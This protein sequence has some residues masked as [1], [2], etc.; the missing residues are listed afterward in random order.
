MKFLDE[1]QS[2]AV[3]RRKIEGTNDDG[4]LANL[5]LQA[6]EGDAVSK[7]EEIMRFI[8]CNLTASKLR[9]D[10]PK[11]DLRRV[12]ERLHFIVNVKKDLTGQAM[13]SVVQEYAD[14]S[15]SAYDALVVCVL[16]HGMERT[17][18]GVDGEEVL[19]KKLY[20]PFTA[21]RTL[22]SKPKL[23]FIQACQGVAYQKGQIVED[24]PKEQLDELF[25][26]DVPNPLLHKPS[27]AVEADVLIGMSTVEE[28]K[29]FRH[30]TFGSIYIQALC[31]AL[32]SGC[33]KK[34]NLLTILT[35]VNK[36]VSIHDYN[37]HKQMPQLQSTL[38][39]KLV[40]T[41]D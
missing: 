24:G 8:G 18:L 12:F 38:T 37:T 9:E 29:S 25:E 36:E 20:R 16:S 26:E 15:H 13:K 34:E 3:T 17:V 22:T 2:T 21:C 14:K 30:T 33:P 7:T 1:A 27:V 40:L 19:I 32:E 39:T 23:F 11:K 4:D 31:R 5:L 6:Y 35:R 10:Y 41:V 28:F